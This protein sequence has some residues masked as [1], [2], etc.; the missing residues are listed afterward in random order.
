MITNPL[1]I[2]KLLELLQF[3]VLLG[4]ALIVLT[5]VAS[6]VLSGARAFVNGEIIWS[7]AQKE[8]PLSLA[9][10]CSSNIAN[11]TRILR[12]LLGSI[13]GESTLGM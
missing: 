7:K 6:K 12:N 4:L 9:A 10:I 11:I 1:I 3:S 8:T 5:N 13:R 2:K